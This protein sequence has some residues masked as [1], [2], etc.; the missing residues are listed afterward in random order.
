MHLDEDHQRKILENVYADD[1][2]QSYLHIILLDFCICAILVPI[3]GSFAGLALTKRQTQ[4][5][6]NDYNKW[7]S[8]TQDWSNWLVPVIKRRSKTTKSITSEVASTLVTRSPNE[9]REENALPAD[10]QTL[11][12]RFEIPLRPG[13]VSFVSTPV[14]LTKSEAEKIKKYIDY[15]ILIAKDD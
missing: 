7:G 3:Q 6:I 12:T 2:V 5:V 13:I 15:L 14:D 8:S 1:Y 4:K 9:S 11:S 10:R